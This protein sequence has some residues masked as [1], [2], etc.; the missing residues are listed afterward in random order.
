M[1]GIFRAF[2]WM[3]VRVLVNSLERTGSRDT[4]ERFS[5]AVEKLGPIVA[6]VVL[7]PSALVLFVLGIATGFA[8][9]QS[10]STITLTIVRYFLLLVLV[11]T[12]FGPMML[13]IRDSGGLVRYLLLPI[14]RFSL[15][16]AQMTGGL[17]DPWVLLV[18]PVVVLGIPIGLAVG[19]SF[20]A[21]AIALV[22][23]LAFLLLLTGIT[24][25]A[26]SVIHLLLRDR[27]R[28]DLVMLVVIFLL[29][30]ISILPQLMTPST[31]RAPDGRKLTRAERRAQPPSPTARAALRLA[32][33]VPS[34]MY[35]R[36]A[37]ASV[38]SP[39]G[40]AIP[41]A[42]LAGVAFLVQAAA[43]VAYRRVLDMPVSLSMRRAG[44]FGGLWDRIVPGLSPA[45]SA[46][47]L[48]QLRLALRTPRGRAAMVTPLLMP[49]F[50]GVVLMRRGNFS[51][52]GIEGEQGLALAAIGAFT[53]ML[54]LLPIAMN[55]FAVDRAGFTRQMLSPIS[56]RELL[57]GKAVG[58]AM[59]AALPASLAFV[60]SL[61]IYR[62]SHPLLWLGL[63]FA[64]VAAYALL[65]PVAAALSAVFPKTVD[66]NSIGNNSNAHQAAMLLGMLS[67][68]A[69]AVIPVGL[70]FVTLAILHRVELLP[71]LL[72]GWA[73][74]AIGLSYLLFIPVRRLVESRCETLAQYY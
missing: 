17:A 55:Q 34:E 22:A 63:I 31:D 66:M 35:R 6:L 70:T 52:P 46:V 50:F 32:P 16:L 71:W 14:P 11:L 21:A 59:I 67:S 60:L 1:L 19:L 61:A 53:S 45:A 25:L 69:S 20:L 48:T 9:A 18:I 38:A 36:T 51:I 26:S 74:I 65:A 4:L 47:A 64:V 23:G 44:S 39:A 13:P 58:N 49:V 5:V 57:L 12:I 68:V 24:S 29:P 41:L 56:I 30:M 15:Y 3:R 10:T 8:L 73:A 7:I 27:R 42:E 72:L 37:G 54:A 62:S 28:G 2:V 43:F 33:Y 40:A